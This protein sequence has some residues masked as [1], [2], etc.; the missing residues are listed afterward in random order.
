MAN[1]RLL[2]PGWSSR[3]LQTVLLDMLSHEPTVDAVAAARLEYARRRREVASRLAD[4][5]VEVTGTDGI[6]LWMRVDN[7]RSA[8]LT[9]AA[10]GIGV[11]PGDPFITDSLG[12]VEFRLGNRAEALRI[13]QG[14][15]KDR[16]DPEIAAHLGEVL[17][18]LGEREQAEKIWRDGMLLHS[19]N[20]T[21]QETVKR[22]KVK[23]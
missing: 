13:L 16:P 2:G 12:W 8:L 5:G 7:Q 20:E 18:T 19:D 3:I 1:R 4:A 10:Q 17:W 21:L 9:L 23:P 15:Y 14:A 11:A 6:N 22:L